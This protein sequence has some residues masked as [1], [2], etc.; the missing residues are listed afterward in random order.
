MRLVRGSYAADREHAARADAHQPALILAGCFDD[1]PEQP[2]LDAIIAGGMRLAYAEDRGQV[3]L[4]ARLLQPQGIVLPS[5]DARGLSTCSI[6]SRCLAQS[7][8]GARVLLLLPL[9]PGARRAGSACACPGVETAAV[10][11]PGELVEAV[12]ALLKA[13][14]RP[15]LRLLA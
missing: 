2:F 12:V 3:L 14:P 13:P 15:T 10:R 9:A 11:T 1:L 5:N 8:A 7:S 4:A 6:V